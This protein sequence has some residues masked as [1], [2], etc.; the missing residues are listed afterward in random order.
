MGEA[1]RHISIMRS[2]NRGTLTRPESTTVWLCRL[3]F[4]KILVKC[5]FKKYAGCLCGTNDDSQVFFC[6]ISGL[7]IAQGNIPLHSYD[8]S[9]L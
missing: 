7:G 4:E 1:R 5:L 2:D 8:P 9:V 3:T 6:W